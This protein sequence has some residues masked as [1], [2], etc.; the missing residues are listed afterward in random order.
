MQ[1]IE[2]LV[3]RFLQK[4]VSGFERDYFTVAGLRDQRFGAHWRRHLVTGA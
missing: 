1:S 2:C 4:G 3:W